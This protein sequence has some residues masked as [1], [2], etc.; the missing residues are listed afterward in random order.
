MKTRHAIAIV[1]LAATVV[2]PANANEANYRHF[3]PGIR[4]AGVGASVCA[5]ATDVDACIY[6]PA[7]LARV[8]QNSMSLSANLYGFQNYAIDDFY[9]PGEDLKADSFVTIPSTVG[10][11]FKLNDRATVALSAFM[12][13]R[14]AVSEVKAFSL[15]GHY[16]ALSSEAKTIWLGPSAGYQ[17]TPQIAV[18]ASFFGI[19][20]DYT[21]VESLYWSGYSMSVSQ[22]LKSS[23]LSYA[24]VMG[25][26][27]R[28][29]D[30]VALGLTLRTGSTTV[31]GKGKFLSHYSMGLDQFEN[32]SSTYAED[33]DAEDKLPATITAGV[34]WEDPG[35]WSVGADI[36][37]HLSATYN[38][39]EGTDESGA[40]L[41]LQMKREAVTDFSVGGE[42]ILFG[43]YPLRGGFFTSFSSAPETSLETTD[44]PAHMDLYGI[45]ASV[46]T[47]SD[48][49]SVN[50][51]L[52]YI[53]GS[54]KAYGQDMK[55]G[56]L[57]T[58]LVDATE[59]GLYVFLSTS[60]CF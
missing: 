51:G 17:L 39:L 8:Q 48:H 21:R 43:K 14:F 27:Y 29:T 4:A 55:D 2:L 3:L 31:K 47:V 5:S 7:G 23:T 53:F 25:L 24:G 59:N 30:V 32:S 37:H 42:Y 26:Q 12:P 1:G 58:S 20:R 50:T 36:T 22:N 57:Q 16:N 35:K 15:N 33:M 13:D 41:A 46:G 52:N 6:N 54:G 56:L 45:T 44:F 34:S 18:G 10:S 19:Y 28:P 9:F 11:V 38:S 60:Y 40:R 49:V